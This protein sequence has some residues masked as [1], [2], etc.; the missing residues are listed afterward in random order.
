MAQT[1]MSRTLGRQPTRENV[2]TE[3]YRFERNIRNDYKRVITTGFGGKFIPVMA[4]PLLREDRMLSS[5]FRFSFEMAETSDMLLNPVRI[6][7]HAWFVP[8]LAFERF[9]DLGHLNRAWNEQEEVDGSTTPWIQQVPFDGAGGRG[10]TWEIYRALGLHAPAGAMVNADY[11]EAYNLIWNYIAKQTSPSLTERQWNQ[12]ALAPAFWMHNAMKHVKPTFD[13][14]LVH[15]QIPVTITEGAEMHLRSDEYSQ[16]SNQGGSPGVNVTFPGSM[17]EQPREEGSH[18]AWDVLGH[19]MWTELNEGGFEI[20]LATIDHA[21]KTTAFAIARQQY[22]GLDDDT[23]IDMLM[24]GIRIPEEGMKHPILLGRAETVF[25]MSQRYATDADNLE[26]SVTR[27]LS[28]L[29]LRLMVPQQNTS[30]IVMA[31]AEILPEQ[32]YERQ[33]DH[34]F[35]ASE[36]SDFPDR[37]RDELDLEPVEVVQ[38]QHVDQDHTDPTGV[39]GY[40]PLNHKWLRQGPNVGGLYHR[41]QADEPWNEYR[42]RI[43]AV[44]TID[45]SLGDD[46]YLASNLHHQVFADSL[47]DPFEIRCNGIAVI[48]GNTMFGPALR[49]S[50]GDYEAVKA[51]GDL[52]KIDLPDPE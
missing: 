28:Q 48:E 13:Q 1:G 35:T 44:E 31:I 41:I 43:W 50:H 5:T 46:F 37:L 36:V 20:S 51:K 29:D 10:T 26:K 2:R 39:F 9:M 6:A 3:P 4:I 15:G 49:E 24:S 14:A 17:D 38:N 11:Q 25:G 40:A 52:S 45:P 7:V 21:R 32:L 16:A 22:Q 12:H 33:E 27:G 8:K 18:Y 34:Y 47:T 42:N 19:R 23:L 30:G